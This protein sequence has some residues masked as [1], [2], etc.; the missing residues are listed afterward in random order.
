MKI[1]VDTNIIIDDLAIREPFAESAAAIL[2]LCMN[3]DVKGYIAAHSITNIFYILKSNFT[4]TERRNALKRICIFLEV[5]GIDN[6]KIIAALDNNDFTDFE[7]CLQAECAR[8]L[9]LDYIVTR[10]T[11]DFKNSTVTALTPDEFLERIKL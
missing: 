11:K 3:G 10:N 4:V 5:I 1:L 8:S 2:K 7:D 6:Q 9:Q